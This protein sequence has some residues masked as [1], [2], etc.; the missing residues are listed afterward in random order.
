MKPVIF[1]TKV[2][3]SKI[4]QRDWTPTNLWECMLM[5][6]LICTISVTHEY[7]NKQRNYSLM[8]IWSWEFLATKR[9]SGRRERLWCHRK[10]GAIFCDTV[11][12]WM[13][14]SVLAH[15]WSHWTLSMR[16]I[17]T[18]LP[19]MMLLMVAL[20]KKISMQGLRRLANLW[21]LSVQKEFQP[22]MS[23]YESSKITTYMRSAVSSA[24]TIAK[25]SAS[26]GKSI[27]NWSGA[28]DLPNTW[29][30]MATS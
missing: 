10:R 12:G 24:A 19:T 5:A 13:K 28:I 15:G 1:P 3:R 2:F 26:P 30:S 27:R 14:S 23:S 7:L 21:Q 6:S 11:S 25:R 18:M 20:A 16:T 9:P 8:C 22:Q 29:Q 4:H 17:S